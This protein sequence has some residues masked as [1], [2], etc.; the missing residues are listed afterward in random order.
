MGQDF[1]I[2]SGIYPPDT[3]GPA[4][5]AETFSK[6]LT[7]HGHTIRILTYTNFKS[8][9]QKK[10]DIAIYALSRSTPLVSRYMKMIYQIS[11]VVYQRMNILANG[12]FIE[13][14]LV[15]I[16]W[17]FDY[18]VKIPGDIVWERA[19][20]SGLTTLNI[21]EF[22]SAKVNY[23]YQI[24][25]KLF[26]FSIQNANHIIVPSSHLKSLC[27]SWGA[28]SRKISVIYN[29]ISVE[30]FPFLNS[31]KQEFDI[32]T[33]SRL[34]PWKGISE[35]IEVA[36]QLQ[37][38]LLIVGDGPQRYELE[39]LSNKLAADVTFTGDIPQ[40]ELPALY[41]K[42]KI[43]VLNSSFEATSYALLEARAS[44]LVTIANENTGSEE[45]I[46][47]MKDGLLCGP[48][49]GL[50]LN[51]ALSLLKSGSVDYESF[52]LKARESVELEFNQNMN[53]AA[54]MELCS[55]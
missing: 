39:T 25:R 1:C 51:T 20:N 13:I 18:S 8:Y 53:F 55:K 52:R 37:M 24:F 19:R 21:D 44:G 16:F 5:F 50:T 42:S 35:L 36:A 34:V 15:R 29:S 33:V 28:D 3:G 11:K 31:T 6:F 40:D 22:Q 54:I 48:K 14:A 23:R 27:I 38:K 43:F 32:M 4:K 26:S 41:A 45:V 2:L 17:R 9:R 30:K 47:H 12:C 7:K 49:Y 10:E 46:S